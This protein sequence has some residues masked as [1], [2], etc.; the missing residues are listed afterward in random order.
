MFTPHTEHIFQSLNVNSL[1][2]IRDQNK[3]SMIL[4]NHINV[5]FILMFQQWN[6]TGSLDFNFQLKRTEKNQRDDSSKE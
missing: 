2:G 6:S 5:F 4:G 1:I 3:T